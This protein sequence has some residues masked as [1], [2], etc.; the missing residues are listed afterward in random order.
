M[1]DTTMDDIT[2]ISLDRGV[3]RD[4]LEETSEV[5]PRP[6]SAVGDHLG[7]YPTFSQKHCLQIQILVELTC[8]HSLKTLLSTHQPFTGYQIPRFIFFIEYRH[9]FYMIYIRN[10]MASG[11]LLTLHFKTLLT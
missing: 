3:L 9:H 6:G 11:I 7:S 10:L 8:L 2:R 1:D 4:I 5:A